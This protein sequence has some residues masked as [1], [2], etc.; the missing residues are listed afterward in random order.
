MPSLLTQT[1]EEQLTQT[2]EEQLTQTREEQVIPI[3]L[4]F[5]FSNTLLPGSSLATKILSTSFSS[6]FTLSFE[7]IFLA[8][9]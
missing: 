4:V 3:L 7:Q 8:L 5:S 9:C 6:A 2:R 1:R